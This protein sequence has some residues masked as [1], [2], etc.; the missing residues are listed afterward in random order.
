MVFQN[1]MSALN[2]GFYVTSAL[3]LGGFAYAVHAM[4]N[5]PGVEWTWLRGCGIVGMVTAF[6]FVWITQ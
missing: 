1:P 5:G 6:L 3:A 4:L 2:R